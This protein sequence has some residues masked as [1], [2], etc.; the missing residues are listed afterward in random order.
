[1]ERAGTLLRAT[2]LLLTFLLLSFLLS[3]LLVLT[4]RSRRLRMGHADDGEARRD[5]KTLRSKC[6]FNHK[7]QP[8]RGGNHQRSHF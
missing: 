4:R 7:P 2:A 8:D 3:D 5:R 1:L 6:N